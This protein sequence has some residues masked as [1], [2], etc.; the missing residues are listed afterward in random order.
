MYGPLRKLERL[1][2]YYFPTG[3]GGATAGILASYLDQ[4]TM[5]SCV[6]YLQTNIKNASPTVLEQ[7]HKTFSVAVPQALAAAKDLTAGNFWQEWEKAFY[8]IQAALQ[9]SVLAGGTK[10]ASTS[11]QHS[12]KQAGSQFDRAL[13]ILEL[14]SE[15]LATFSRLV[16]Q[17]GIFL[18]RHAAKLLVLFIQRLDRLIKTK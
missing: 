15:R 3:E 2:L 9:N 5:P 6:I 4:A 12:L 1:A 16:S 13:A 8:Q 14:P 17:T 18:V 10:I 11:V 7:I